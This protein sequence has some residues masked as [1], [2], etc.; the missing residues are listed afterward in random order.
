V[1]IHSRKG[2]NGYFFVMPDTVHRSADTPV[3]R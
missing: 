2:S 3:K 1:K